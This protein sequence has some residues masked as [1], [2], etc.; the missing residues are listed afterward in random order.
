[1]LLT[2]NT[3]KEEDWGRL[4][5]D[6]DSGLCVLLVDPLTGA[7]V[8]AA[9]GKKEAESQN[10]EALEGAFNILFTSGSTGP[11]KGVRDETRSIDRHQHALAS[12]LCQAAPG[13]A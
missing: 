8:E 4:T 5:S 2:T 13:R 7:V 10:D 9:G 12:L 6:C 11:P 1:M 3:S